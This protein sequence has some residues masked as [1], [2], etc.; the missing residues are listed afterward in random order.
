MWQL[1]YVAVA[2]SLLGCDPQLD[3]A[4]T[5]VSGD[6]QAHERTLQYPVAI[7][8][9]QTVQAILITNRKNA[10]DVAADADS[11]RSRAGFIT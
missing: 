1:F 3:V 10:I 7:D 4:K 9:S 6:P 5:G 8:G 11:L 2:R